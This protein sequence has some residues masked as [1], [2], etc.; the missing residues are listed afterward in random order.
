MEQ[1]ADVVI[2]AVGL[3]GLMLIG[4]HEGGLRRANW[5]SLRDHW[6]RR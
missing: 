3:A 2:V 1:M 6:H 5:R 4:V